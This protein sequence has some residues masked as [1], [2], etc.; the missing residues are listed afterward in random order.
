M[1][2]IRI[3]TPMRS[4]TEGLKEVEVSAETVGEA[5]C[6]VVQRY[7]SIKQHLYDEADKLRPYVN[8]FINEEEI[9]TLRGEDTPIKEGDRLMIVPSLAGGKDVDI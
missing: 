4:Y 9:R 2:V 6:E 1:I 3:P 8:V 5:L 7:P